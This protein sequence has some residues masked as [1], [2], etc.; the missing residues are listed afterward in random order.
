[1]F[2]RIHRIVN[3]TQ[4]EVI[5]NTETNDLKTQ[6]SLEGG[7][8]F[9]F[10]ITPKNLRESDLLAIEYIETSG[11]GGGG[12]GGGDASSANQVAQTN[13][14]IAIK[15][16]IIASPAT[17]ATNLAIL[18]EL[19][20][21]VF[22]QS[23]IW[24]DRSSVVSVFY[25]EERIRSQDD[26]TISTVYTRLSDN[27][28]VGSLPA[29]SVPVAGSTDRTIEFYRWKANANGTGYTAGDW[30][31]NTIV[32]DTGG[33][34]EVLSSTWYNLSTSATISA[35]TNSHLQD[36]NE[37]ILTEIRDKIISSPA[38]EGKQDLEITELTAIKT[39]IQTKEISEIP[40]DDT[41]SLA[42]ATRA[43]PQHVSRIGFAKAIANG[44]DTQ[45]FE[46]PVIG[47]GQ[48]VNQTG[49][50]LVITS[51]TTARSETIIRSLASWKGGIR[52]RAKVTLSQRIVNQNF[53]AEL[54]DVIGDNL[55]Y[56]ITSAT[57]MTVTIPANTLTAENVGQSISI[58]KF[59]GTG[60]FLSGRYTIASVS[61]NDV[62]FTVSG[63]AVGSGTCSLFGLNFYRLLYD[64]TS[65]TNVLYQNQR[66]GYANSAISATINTT[67]TIGHI[68]IVTANDLTC[69]FS[70]QSPISAVGSVNTVRAQQFE[71]VPDD[72]D[73]RLQIRVLNLGTAPASSTTFTV[74]FVS[75]S[76]FSAQDVSIQDV[77]P[78]TP[79]GLTV[80]IVKAIALAITG[81]VTANIGTGSLSAGTNAVGDF[82]MQYRANNTGAGSYAIV[83]SPAT[84][85][86]QT[87]K[88]TAGRLIGFYLTN[89]NASLRF[90]KIFNIASPTLGTTAAVLDISIPPTNN[91]AFISFEGGLAFSTAI[92]CAITGDKGTTNNTPITL[93]EV[94]GF[95]VFA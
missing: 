36:P 59:A 78:T 18:A 94:A 30:L 84:P 11:G 7:V 82:G 28:V 37:E 71:N 40:S 63:F 45:F 41:D 15:N 44:V 56:N 39:L 23:T 87:I 22:I 86:V 73:L 1:V 46:T 85:A 60:T 14:L 2:E 31:T 4:K 47:S 50:N 72:K 17:E 10:G 12:G 80:D 21:D 19:R 95:L 89:A 69:S 16:K 57:T 42:L 77:R 35:P 70:D 74:G 43:L 38:T 9:T 13:E 6:A 88:G 27:V 24:E 26:G 5:Y 8:I 66:N 65:A 76:N 25:R 29:G 49:G 79:Q 34:G 67:A 51:G 91:P 92:T 48:T 93:N 20:D 75:I 32:F 54:V 83:N 68:A 62:V 55:A 61:G 64:G 52:L 33:I 3:L 81:T 53:I 58:G 90:L